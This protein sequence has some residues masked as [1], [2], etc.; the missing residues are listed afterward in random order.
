MAT[1]HPRIPRRIFMRL[2]QVWRV[3]RKRT[4]SFVFARDA[5][6]SLLESGVKEVA[7]FQ[8]ARGGA[9]PSMA[10]S[11]APLIMMYFRSVCQGAHPASEV[12][13]RNDAEFEVLAT[14]IDLS[15][16]ILQP[17]R[18]VIGA[19]GNARRSAASIQ[20]RFQGARGHL[21]RWPRRWWQGRLIDAA[22]AWPSLGFERPWPGGC[23]GR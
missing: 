18:R 3:R 9:D 11:P 8:Q 14:I 17:R 19:A 22:G 13:A 16:R 6:G 12:G 2:L 15:V 1:S 21:C 4:R 7:E 23:L 20:S 10:D 5:P